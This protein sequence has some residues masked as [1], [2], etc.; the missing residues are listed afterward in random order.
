MNL[1][2]A[3]DI[4]IAYGDTHIPYQNKGKEKII[5][6]IIKDVKPDGI[7]HGGDIINAECLMEYPKSWDQLAGL[8]EQIDE[9]VA[10]MER[11]NKAAPKAWKV[12]LKD[13]HFFNRLEMKKKGQYWLNGLS[14][15]SPEHLLDLKRL[16]WRAEKKYKWKDRVLFV[17][18][19][20]QSMCGKSVCP[21]NKVRSMVR[22]SG[23]SVVRFH[24]HTTGIE[25]HSID[26]KDHL[27]MQLASFHD[28]ADADY[29][30]VEE[31]NNWSTSAAVFYFS[32]QSKQFVACPLL[33]FNG[34]VIF[35]DKLYTV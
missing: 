11:V 23:M 34:T 25:I 10:H 5:L 14:A 33:F 32:K 6:D 9:G 8:Q 28:V 22:D 29:I 27:A 21:A 24:S 15:I 35:N 1:R 12:L 19:D 30:P 13:N 4:V 26:G 16:G 31:T 20:F 18:G 17:H 3:Y 7:I 2:K